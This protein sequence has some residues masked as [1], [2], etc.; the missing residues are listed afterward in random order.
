MN[1]MRFL[2]YLFLCVFLIGCG[3]R[4]SRTVWKHAGGQF[5]RV[6]RRTWVET[7][8][9][10]THNF[11]E[12]H[13][14]STMIEL[15]DKTR[16]I[17]VC[18]YEDH[19]TATLG[20]FGPNFLYEGGWEGR[21][22]KTA[23][24]S[25]SNSPS[26]S[27]DSL[28]EWL[29][30]PNLKSKLADE[31]EANG[32]KV[33]PPRDFKLEKRVQGATQAYIWQGPTRPDQSTPKFWV[34]VGKLN[35]NEKNSPL[36]HTLAILQNSARSKLTSYSETPGE[37]G[38]IGGL[39]FLRITFTGKEHGPPEY[40]GKGIVYHAHDGDRYIHILV[41]DNEA[42]QQESFPLLEAAALSFRR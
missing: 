22:V 6:S 11:T 34:M 33:C 35:E 32:Y 17:T 38:R 7:A 1:T 14:D 31:F 40:T 29:P 4:D 24:T 26:T 36:E 25:N 18:L 3:S 19:S 10:G 12:A 8:S 27:E 15:T 28:S 42:Y 16:A 20:D 13:R 5:E 2:P 30:K 23:S 9:D 41:M 21:N 37:R 39:T